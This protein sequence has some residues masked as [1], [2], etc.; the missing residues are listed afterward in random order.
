[1]FDPLPESHSGMGSVRTAEVLNYRAALPPV[2]SI[3]HA[4]ALL[5]A[6]ASNPS[7]VARDIE[8]AARSGNIRKIIIP[9]RGGLGETLIPISELEALVTRA[10]EKG[11]IDMPTKNGFLAYLRSNPGTTRVPRT[12]PS[13]DG[14]GLLLDVKQTDALIRAGFLTSQSGQNGGHIVSSFS[15][16]ED[17]YTLMSLETVANAT[18]GTFHAVGGRDVIHS[19]GGTGIPSAMD[20]LTTTLSLAV[21]GNGTYLKLVAAAVAHLTSL[22]EKAQYREMTETSLKEKWNGGIAGDAASLAKRSRGE[23]VGILPGRTKKWKDFYGLRF[24]WVLD[25]A[26][27]M[28]VVEGFDTGSVGRGI[29][30]VV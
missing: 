10:Q 27:G 8:Q 30:L 2:A 24:E 29:R 22:L 17:K 3:P 11:L 1:M 19:S 28:G 21:P 26:L 13:P 7:A 15:R 25:E 16:P 18:S 5:S 23:F 12:V 6:T 14:R 9:M 20:T 4:T